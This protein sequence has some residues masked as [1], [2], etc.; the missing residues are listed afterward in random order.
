M[1]DQDPDAFF[2][3][4]VSLGRTESCLRRY[5]A[6]T[7]VHVVIGQVRLL[8]SHWSMPRCMMLISR[9]ISVQ[10]THAR[11]MTASCRKR[12]ELLQLRHF[13]NLPSY[14]LQASSHHST[15]KALSPPSSDLPTEAFGIAA[16]QAAE[17]RRF[18]P[19]TDQVRAAAIA[20]DRRCLNHFSD[21]LEYISWR[22]P[23]LRDRYHSR[24]TPPP[25]SHLITPDSYTRA[26]QHRTTLRICH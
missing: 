21:I 6:S 20:F 23:D 17:A 4:T 9:R 13:V 19:L 22:S 5:M 12:V 16:S 18:L 3:C 1:S 25:T 26:L 2:L 11:C 15:A 10:Q 14:N 24:H 7:M 8:S